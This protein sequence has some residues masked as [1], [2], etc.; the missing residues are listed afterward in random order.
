MAVPAFVPLFP[1]EQPKQCC[2]VKTEDKRMSC[3][4]CSAAA[5]E[6]LELISGSTYLEK[7]WLSSIF[8]RKIS[9]KL[10]FYYD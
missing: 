9:G 7:I 2:Y 6:H 5:A 3:E 4:K 10:P 8:L 1:H